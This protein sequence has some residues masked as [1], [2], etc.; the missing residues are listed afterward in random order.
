MQKAG[1]IRITFLVL[2]V[3]LGLGKSLHAQTT[4]DN[5]DFNQKSLEITDSTNG[6]TSNRLVTSQPETPTK[7]TLTIPNVFTPNG[8]GVCDFFEVT[9]TGTSMLVFKVFTRTGALVYQTKTS[10]IKWDG[11]NEDGK[12]LPEGIYYY[13]IEDTNKN[14]ENA[15]GFLYI[16]R[17]KK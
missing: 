6:T 12:E 15:K 8:D 5:K 4:L 7:A 16:F 2:T 9:T 17:G 14:Y 1:L 10:Y 3:Y 13:I 11:K